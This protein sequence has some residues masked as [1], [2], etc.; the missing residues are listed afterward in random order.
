MWIYGDWPH[1][2]PV[3]ASLKMS[4]FENKMLH[5]ITLREVG[6]MNHL[7]I[8]NHTHA[9]RSMK[10]SGKTR[11]LRGDFIRLFLHPIPRGQN[12]LNSVVRKREFTKMIDIELKPV[13]FDGYRSFLISVPIYELA[14]S[15]PQPKKQMPIISSPHQDFFAHKK[16]MDTY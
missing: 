4:I 8:P 1:N 9:G 12:I 13:S 11:S 15:V 2:F 14:K 7:N 3:L 6:R 10:D 5:F 16:T